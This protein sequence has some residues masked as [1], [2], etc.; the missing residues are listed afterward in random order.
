MALENIEEI[1]DLRKLDLKQLDELSKDLR[2]YILEVISKNGG[3]LASSMGVVELTIALHYVFNTPTDRIIWD[4]GHQTYAH[5]I[6]TG[7]KKQFSTIRKYEGIS[8]FP[9]V[10]ESEYDCY[11]TGHSSTSLSLAIGE[12]IAR[13]LQN[14]DNKVIAVIGDGA[15]T[16]GMAF[17]ALNQIGHLKKDM[18]IVLNDNNHS[19]SENVGA[20][21]EHLTDVITNRYY[22][23]LRKS[24]YLI[25]KKIPLIGKM[26]S[27]FILKF[28]IGVKRLFIPTS[29]FEEL[30][31]RY[32]GPVDGHNTKHLVRLFKRIKNLK[33][34]PKIVH[35]VTKK[36][37]G[38]SYAE[39]DPTKFHGISNFEISSGNSPKKKCMTFSDVAGRSLEVLAK[40]DEKI[41][42]IT[43]AMTEGTGLSGFAEKFPDKFIDVG[44]AEQ[45]AT[46]LAS[47]LANRGFKPFFAVY[48]SFL[49]R[50]YDQIV[51]DVSLMKL[52][53]KFLIDR[54]G[55]VG[56][57][58]E[59]HHGL[60]DPSFLK[61]VPNIKIMNASNGREL[62]ELIKY[63]S[64]YNEGPIAVR[65]PRGSID[66]EN[67]IDFNN[68]KV[69]EADINIKS[70]VSGS[71]IAI[72]TY[73]DTVELSVSCS[74]KL[75]ESSISASVHNLITIFPPDYN[76]I[77]S[78]LNKKKGFI[79]IENAYEV[80]SISETACLNLS[81]DNRKKYIKTFAFPNMCICHGSKEQIFEKYDITEKNIVS[82]VKKY[83][84]SYEK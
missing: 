52:P 73:S 82:T 63:A 31:L 49:Q 45:H 39:K 37:K 9:K 51:H 79:F 42:A 56:E 55:V 43:A 50:A 68:H 47:S 58:G 41:I 21:S 33:N 14:E 48:S 11:N 57:D 40:K 34:G 81:A 76:K 65:Y 12:A 69:N 26:L 3:H 23:S 35:I 1:E 36:G 70:I 44:I 27:K 17:E 24:Y 20:L 72:F 60:L 59:T 2:K 6:L 5:K 30:G 18:I 62:F 7:R 16:G 4:V 67:L 84:K 10:C 22:N 28:E 25:L 38:Y 19:I 66:D 71:D 13:D 64:L 54:A 29:I 77:N 78:I 75:K 61:S 46:T 83:L 74:K 15:M 8:G 80:G 53:V 32:F